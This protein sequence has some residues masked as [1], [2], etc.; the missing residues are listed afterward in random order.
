[1]TEAI[2][3]GRTLA[4]TRG[5]PEA[6]TLASESPDPREVR[7]VALWLGSPERPQFC[8]LD[9]P[10]D[11]LIAGAAVLCPSMGL[12]AAYS[13]RA[14]RDL[15]RG[16][17]ASGWVALRVDYTG[18]GDSAGTW[19]DPDLVTDWL[20]D[21]RAAIDYAR[22]LGAPRV[23]V[24]GLRIGAT[25]AAAELARGEAVDDLV[26]W[27]PCATGK[28]F[29]REQRALWAFLRDQ[30]TEWGILREG[31]VWGSAAA[32]DDGS[33]EAPGVM[34]SAATVEELEPLAIAPGGRSLASRELLLARAGRKLARGLAERPT[35]PHVEW[36]EVRGQE[37]LLDV[38]ALTPEAT[39]ERIIS[40]LTET[41][42]APIRIEV[43]DEH[44]AAVLRTQGLSSVLERPLEL[45]P[46]GLFGM[47]SEPETDLLPSA[48]TVVF[49]NAGRIGHQGPARLWVD[50]ARRWASEGIRC[51]RVDLN[52]LGDS[53][54]RAGR[55]ELVEF[56]AD[57]LQDLDDIRRAVSPGS[58]ADVI[59]VGLCSGGYHAVESGLIAPVASVC[60]VN[61]ALTPFLSVDPP[62]RRFEPGEATR[63]D[64][65]EALGSTPSWLSQAA[66][67]ERVRTV[68]GSI[69]GTWWVVK[70]LMKATP[71]R[72]L[73][74]LT[75]S[76][77]DVLMVNGGVEDNLMRRGEQ[78]RFRALLRKG[79]LTMETIPGLEHTLLERTGRDQVSALLHAYVT[80]RAP[81]ASPPTDPVAAE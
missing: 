5:E 12:E 2:S 18:M 38:S 81:D 1:M 40:W 31:E 69:P 28:A 25:L 44:A 80:R 17:A 56:P 26:L 16:L 76:G 15:A 77:V 47:L 30:A 63:Y 46:T 27:D 41:R 45:G 52:G 21:V 39:L 36:S 50:L 55:T 71:G 19:T 72:S 62:H 13:A 79:R 43:P 11:R 9:V 74:R 78:R 6:Q 75:Q 35:L 23:G 22:D 53:P 34:F 61:P 57:A 37:A 54:T 20:G 32:A 3:N 51:V 59:L 60:L 10:H 64:D 24:V 70:R 58:D 8:W 33:F 49:L 73:T 14:L 7:S 65:R 68:V 29:L 4:R 42:E 67:L 66:R 48:P